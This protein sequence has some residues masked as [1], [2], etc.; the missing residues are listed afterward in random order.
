MGER[1]S[2]AFFDSSVPKIVTRCC[3]SRSRSDFP[4]A[5]AA[6]QGRA[7]RAH[8][9]PGSGP[10]WILERR[11]PDA[12]T[13]RLQALRP[14]SFSGVTMNSRRGPPR[15]LT[16]RQIRQVLAWHQAWQTFRAKHESVRRL[17]T[18]LGVSETVIYYCIRRYR[19][20]S[21]RTS[22]AERPIARLTVRR[23]RPPSLSDAKL[24][25][26]IA[27]YVRYLNFVART[28]GPQTIA[29]RLG[30]SERTLYDCIHRRGC[31]AIASRCPSTSQKRKEIE[32]Q[33]RAVLLNQWRR[34]FSSRVR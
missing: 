4:H 3:S 26:V 24:A 9:R 2:R 13:L 14:H 21:H 7:R 33:A 8:S 18:R 19:L 6:V 30:V 32:S 28:G 25:I 17:A 1:L 20:G 31:Y 10:S 29:R 12:G 34:G 15:I 16:Q 23:G 22:P 5:A 27:W 11:L